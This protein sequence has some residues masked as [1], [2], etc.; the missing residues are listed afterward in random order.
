MTNVMETI[1][2][3][4][5]FMASMEANRAIIAL[6]ELGMDTLD[7]DDG[8]VHHYGNGEYHGTE[9]SKLILNPMM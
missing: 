6:V 2:P 3:P 4:N 9:V 5:S 8:I 7:D 1:A